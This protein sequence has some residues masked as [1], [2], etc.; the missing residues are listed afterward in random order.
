M[1]VASRAAQLFEQW[2]CVASYEELRCAV[3]D[4]VPLIE[5]TFSCNGKEHRWHRVADP[6]QL[7]DEAVETS[8]R[9]AV[10]ID[11]FWAVTWRAASGLAEYLGR[12]DLKDQRVLELGCGSGMAGFAA[13][14]L[15]AHVT[16]T[17]AVEL[18]LLVARLN[19][20]TMR[21]RIQLKRLRWQD[22]SLNEARFP[23]ILSSDLVYDPNHFEVLEMCARN[24]LTDDGYWLLSEPHRHTGDKFSKWIV[25]K[26]WHCREIDL[27]MAD[28]RIPIR[29]FECTLR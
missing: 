15:G 25:G 22:P 8:D 26:G 11:P 6:D 1:T 28:R 14:C 17:D 21:D 18:A 23:Y 13:A 29:I 2:D 3:S 16:M 20:W 4:I 12:I 10:D 24:H 19:T 5:T 7:L 9:S 27:D